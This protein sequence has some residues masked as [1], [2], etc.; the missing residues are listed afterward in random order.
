MG[1][2]EEHL[3]HLFEPFYRVDQARSST[4]G[5]SG[6]GLSIARRIVE[7]HGGKIDVQSALGKGS[8]FTIYLPV[9]QV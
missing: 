8:I 9:Q 3:P 6:L 2:A 1:I 5:R 4:N 7:A